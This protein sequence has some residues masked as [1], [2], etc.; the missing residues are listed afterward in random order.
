M[1]VFIALLRGVN[2]SGQKLIKMDALRELFV[3][4]GFEKVET[5]IQSG[6][7]VFQSIN[8][9]QRELEQIISAGLKDAFGFE[10]PV[11]VL[12]VKELKDITRKNPFINNDSKDKSCMH[13]TFLSVEPEM[14]LFEN[15]KK[16][17]YKGEEFE[18]A[19]KALYLYCPKGYGKTR[20]NNTFLEKK[21]KVTA[22]TR[23]WKT[24]NTL[25]EMAA[26]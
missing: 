12:A 8:P 6:N 18:L 19:G 25:L 4:M 11:L 23:N 2:V 15:L 22:T 10:I 14:T 9:N 3:K 5:Y 17:E 16:L 7:I 24:V 21:L 13:V 26:D 1:P 20:L